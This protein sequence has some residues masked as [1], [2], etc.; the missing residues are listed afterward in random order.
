MR[1]H[2]MRAFQTCE[3]AQARKIM[4]EDYLDR[5]DSYRFFEQLGQAIITGA[6]GTNVADLLI[7]LKPNF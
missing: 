7:A 4:A 3:I 5:H 1:D 2:L 6:T